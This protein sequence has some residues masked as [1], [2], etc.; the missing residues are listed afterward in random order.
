MGPKA[1]LVSSCGRRSPSRLDSFSIISGPSRPQKLK[2]FLYFI[3]HN[4]IFSLSFSLSNYNCLQAIMIKKEEL[5]ENMFFFI[6]HHLF[7][8]SFIINYYGQTD[9][10]WKEKG[11]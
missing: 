10:C 2:E 8:F 9:E 7:A 5:R 4:L 1:W 3:F 6:Q 11:L